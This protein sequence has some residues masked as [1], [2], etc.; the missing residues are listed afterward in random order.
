[1]Q[2]LLEPFIFLHIL[3]EVGISPGNYLGKA[4]PNQ[5]FLDLSAILQTP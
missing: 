1:M 3:L 5:A 2:V 4:L